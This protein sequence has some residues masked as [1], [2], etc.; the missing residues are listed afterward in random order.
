MCK[1]ILFSYIL[2]FFKNFF[3]NNKKN[4]SIVD[5]SNYNIAI[6]ILK[7]THSLVFYLYYLFTLKFSVFQSFRLNKLKKFI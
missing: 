3:K 7:K 2:L 6:N 5:N 4:K 1:T